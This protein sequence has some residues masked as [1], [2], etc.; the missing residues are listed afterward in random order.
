[1]PLTHTLFFLVIAMFDAILFYGDF[2]NS[3]FSNSNVIIIVC[4]TF[5]LLVYTVIIS[6]HRITYGNCETV[7]TTKQSFRT[8]WPHY[9]TEYIDFLDLSQSHDT[10]F[11]DLK[12]VIY[13][14]FFK[15][16]FQL[17]FLHCMIKNF[18]TNE[19]KI[20]H[21][22]NRSLYNTTHQLV[23]S[24]KWSF[25]AHCFRAHGKLVYLLSWALFLHIF[26]HLKT[27]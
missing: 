14:H 8:T 12:Y 17:F 15:I 20:L 6:G 18:E 21:L 2:N 19:K 5:P 9:Y 3:R 1:M 26:W 23:S 4:G 13:I 24:I 25:L 27:R 16:F 10:K 11:T 7:H 22:M